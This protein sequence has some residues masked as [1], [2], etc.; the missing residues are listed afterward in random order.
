[1]NAPCLQHTPNL[2][3]YFTKEVKDSTKTALIKAILETL[4]T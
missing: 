3:F 2:L 4:E 1:M